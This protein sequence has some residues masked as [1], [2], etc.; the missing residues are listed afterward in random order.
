MTTSAEREV[1]ARLTAWADAAAPTPSPNLQ[2]FMGPVRPRPVATRAT[3][4]NHGLSMFARAGLGLKVMLAAAALAMTSAAAVGISHVVATSPPDH[5]PAVTPV[6]AGT[7]TSAPPT[8]SAAPSLGRAAAT[9]TEPT[10]VAATQLPGQSSAPSARPTRHASGAPHVLPTSHPSG[11]PTSEPSSAP[12]GNGSDPSQGP[13][14][15]EATPSTATADG[16][17]DSAPD[18][19]AS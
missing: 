19:T 18:P 14:T 8:R 2:R 9:P 3:T 12:E 1:N 6:D 17:N 15:P 10:D 13:P 11:D 7:S 16:S 5:G 4:A